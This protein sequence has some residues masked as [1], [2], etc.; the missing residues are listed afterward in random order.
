MGNAKAP[1]GTGDLLK[2]KRAVRSLLEGVSEDRVGGFWK[3]S[4]NGGN[5]AAQKDPREKKRHPR[6]LWGS[7]SVI[8]RVPRNFQ[9]TRGCKEDRRK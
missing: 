6:K 3:A 8:P 9:N 4:E 7:S 5:W 1:R 2:K